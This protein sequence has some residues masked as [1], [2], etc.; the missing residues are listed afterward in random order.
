MHRPP[1]FEDGFLFLEEPKDEG[2]GTDAALVACVGKT[3]GVPEPKGISLD[4]GFFLSELFLSVCWS[5]DGS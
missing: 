5:C 1:I 2:V 4:A 3:S